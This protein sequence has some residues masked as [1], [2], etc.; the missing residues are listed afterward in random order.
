MALFKR[1][2]EFS[3]ELLKE[4]ERLRMQLAQIEDR[5]Q[6]AAQSPEDWSKL[7]EELP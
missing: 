3:K 1:G 5:Q 6:S 7:R 2:A 4:N